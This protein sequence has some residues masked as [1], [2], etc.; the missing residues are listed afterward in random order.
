MGRQAVFRETRQERSRYL[1][2]LGHL[3]SARARGDTERS[4]GKIGGG[5]VFPA[6]LKPPRVCDV[7]MSPP[8]QER[9]DVHI[10]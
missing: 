6:S 3:P 2:I 7:G 4:E 1:G 9:H 8:R 5:L 10:L